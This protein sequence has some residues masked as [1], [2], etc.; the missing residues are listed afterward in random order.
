MTE[1]THRSDG[2][3]GVDLNEVLRL[4]AVALARMSERMDSY[5][6][7]AA[8]KPSVPPPEAE[9][10]G[11]PHLPVLASEARLTEDSLPVLNAFR[12][13]LEQE[14]RRTRARILWV[15]LSFAVLFAAT[16]TTVMWMG[17]ERLSELRNDLGSTSRRVDERIQAASAEMQ[18]A[19][20]VAG[21][22]ASILKRDMNSTLTMAQST[23]ASNLNA[24]M[25]SRDVEIDL[26]KEK[27]SSLEIENAVLVGRLREATR[28]MEARA[29]GMRE[30]TVAPEEQTAEAESGEPEPGVEK[31]V[32][33][34]RPATNDAMAEFLAPPIV[35]QTPAYNRPVRFKMPAMKP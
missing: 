23:M 31:G 6:T 24:E 10:H 2:E 13:F 12:E 22:T 3:S 26:L 30:E 16:V 9:R 11:S 21:R 34:S 27:L 25:K 4:Q 8:G 1:E 14:R 35:I 20:E 32:A 33:S 15:S 29:E 7:A 17:R 19:S 18:R 5:R 28:S